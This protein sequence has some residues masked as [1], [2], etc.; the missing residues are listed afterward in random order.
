MATVAEKL[1]AC[2]KNDEEIKKLGI[3]NIGSLFEELNSVFNE[4]KSKFLYQSIYAVAD[5]I[6]KEESGIRDSC[7]RIVDAAKSVRDGLESAARNGDEFELFGKAYVALP[8]DVD[9]ETVRAG[10]TLYSK[11]HPSE[12]PVKVVDIS[13]G[14]R[15]VVCD[16]EGDS[17]LPEFYR[18]GPKAVE[19]ILREFVHEFNRDDS[20]LC[21]EEIVEKYASM[22][23]PKQF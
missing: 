14:S 10:D 3:E 19:D 15:W 16:V 7:E 9:G 23:E 2:A 22:L 5:A 20:E 4:G 6:E 13:Y 8:V 18:H 21:D 1:R 11:L 12:K 17:Y